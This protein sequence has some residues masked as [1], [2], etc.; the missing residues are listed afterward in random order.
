MKRTKGFTLV[1]LIVVIA[2]LGVLTTIAVFNY[3]N[4]QRKARDDQRASDSALIADSLEKFFA[5]N[6]EYPSVAEMT[7]ADGNVV[8]TLLGLNSLDGLVAPSASSGTTN[9]WKTGT[10]TLTN[11]F[12][13]SGNTDNSASCLTGTTAADSCTDYKLQYYSEQTGTYVT[14]PSRNKTVSLNVT[15]REGVVAPTAPTVTAALAGANATGTSTVP[16]C[17]AGATTQLAFRNRSNDGTWGSWTSWSTTTTN[18]TPAAQGVKYGFQAKAVCTLNSVNSAESPVS[19]EATYVHPIST[20]ATPSVYTTASFRPN[21]NGGLC[22]DANGG[23][24]VNTVIQIYACNGTAAQDWAYNSNDK[25]IRPTYNT[26]LCITNP[27]KGIQLT[28]QTC[29]GNIVRQ[30]SRYDDGTFHSVSGNYCMDATNFGTANGTTITPWD[31][32]GATAQI[33]N[34]SDSQSAWKWSAISCPAGTNPD[35][36]VNWQTTALADSGWKAASDAINQRDVRTTVNQGYTYTTQVQSRCYNAYATSSWSGTGSASLQKAVLEPGGPS[37]WSY[38]MYGN[39]SQ[40]GWWFSSPTCGAATSISYQE[41]SWIGVNNNG[42]G[43]IL[44]WLGPRTPN[45]PGYI[46]WYYADSTGGITQDWYAPDGSNNGTTWVTY[47][48]SAPYGV[49]VQARARYRC[50]NW[51]TGRSAYGDWGYSQWQLGINYT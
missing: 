41:D 25:T 33:W 42:G 9:S 44:Y 36:R 16:A 1:E 12:S 15:Q 13:Y 47:P 10:P 7:N 11:P 27:G 19:T 31:C 28:L 30:W 45:G 17:A 49:D 38:Y 48:G 8:K 5:A 32:N 35:Y 26:N 39:R 23:G 21:Y 51:T 20:P 43:S 2:I 14:I 24:G 46:T 6:G 40:W 18:A 50:V 29:D 34:P 22:I 3:L 4:V 37:N